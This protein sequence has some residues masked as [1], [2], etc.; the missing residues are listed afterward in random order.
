LITLAGLAD[1]SGTGRAASGGSRVNG[2]TY[3]IVGGSLTRRNLLG[4]LA[5][6]RPLTVVPVLCY[7]ALL[8][9]CCYVI[10]RLSGGGDPGAQAGCARRRATQDLVWAALPL[11]LLHA[12][13]GFLLAWSA[14]HSNVTACTT[15]SRAWFCW[16]SSANKRTVKKRSVIRRTGRR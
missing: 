5:A 6:R 16:L 12:R 14:T 15:F 11:C 2:G 3:L 9:L 1:V 8:Y 7:A 13:P 10:V 4:L